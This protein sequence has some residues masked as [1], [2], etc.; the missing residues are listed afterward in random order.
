MKEKISSN[1]IKKIFLNLLNLDKAKIRNKRLQLDTSKK[2][3]RHRSL[4]NS[5]IQFS[6]SACAVTNQQAFVIVHK[7]LPSHK[8]LVHNILLNQKK[9]L[10]AHV[11]R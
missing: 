9:C 10:F 4:L 1:F 6:Q 11:D 7:F 5:L 8:Y 2:V 3:L